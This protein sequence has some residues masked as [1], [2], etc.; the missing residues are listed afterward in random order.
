M[1]PHGDLLLIDC[2]ADAAP[3]KYTTTDLLHTGFSPDW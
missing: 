3:Q 2:T 1:K